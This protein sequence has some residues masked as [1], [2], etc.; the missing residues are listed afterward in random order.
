M[1]SSFCFFCLHLTSDCFEMFSREC[2]FHSKIVYNST[3]VYTDLI[4][5]TNSWVPLPGILVRMSESEETS[6]GDSGHLK[7][8]YLDLRDQSGSNIGSDRYI[9]LHLAQ[10]LHPRPPWTLASEATL[11]GVHSATTLTI[12]SGYP[13]QQKLVFN[14]LPFSISVYSFWTV[15][16]DKNTSVSFESY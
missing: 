5:N 2:S 3:S 9:S 10:M 4:I 7:L 6:D 15:F 16:C 11:L 8:W 14:N 1:G 12:Y 13:F